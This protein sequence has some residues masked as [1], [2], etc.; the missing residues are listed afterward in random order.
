MSPGG[1]ESHRLKATIVADANG[2][3]PDTDANADADGEVTII[4]RQKNNT[5]TNDDDND[6]A[7]ERSAVFRRL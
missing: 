4:R 1:K 3:W 2:P 6:A 7:R 5:T